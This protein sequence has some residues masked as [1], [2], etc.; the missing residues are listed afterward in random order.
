MAD[1]KKEDVKTEKMHEHKIEERK[2]EHKHE[3]VKK[4]EEKIFTIPLRK[5]FRKAEK[6]RV[7]YSIRL[8]QDYLK[9][10]AKVEEV[11]LGKNLNDEIWKRGI[12]HPPRRVR[13]TVIKDGTTAK[14][15]LFGHSYA[16]FKAQPAKERKGMKEKLMERLG[17]K[18][19]KKEEE[20]KAT[21]G[22]KKPEEAQKIEQ[23]KVEEE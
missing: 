22:E 20:E 23:H 6:K 15:E 11:K 5:A 14:A 2:E 17:P 7:P 3:I 1:E 16:E 21:K 9:R 18:A 4:S 12:T 10:H 8:I 13:V 19:A